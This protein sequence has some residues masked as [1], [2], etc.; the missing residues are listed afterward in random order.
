MF[1]FFK[2]HFIPHE[3]NDHQP[4]FLRDR[5]IRSLVIIVLFFEIGTFLIPYIP[6][7]DPANNAYTASVLPSVLDDLTNQNRQSQNL[8]VLSVNPVLN[9][10]AQLK[11]NDM[12]E[13]GYFAHIS[14][15]GKAPWYFF[16]KAGYNYEYAGENLAVDFTDSV[17][18]DT[19]WMNSPSHKANILKNAYTEIGTGIAT[20]T[21][22][23]SPT[24][25]VA[26][27]FGKPAKPDTKNIPVKIISEKNTVGKS[28]LSK[29]MGASIEV[30]PEISTS[31]IVAATSVSLQNYSKTNVLTQ[32]I[33]SPRHIVNVILLII[34]LIVIFALLLKLLIKSDK[35]HPVLITNGLIVI[36]LILGIYIVNN[37][38]ARNRFDKTSSFTSFVGQKFDQVK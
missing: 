29:V 5:N 37:Y 4:H 24:I 6:V 14:P 7:L 17:D 20:G 19:A 31:S 10:V 38:I 15:D 13:K 30:A 8:S 27:E 11:A 1:N 28:K 22:E 23:G 12:A 34:V 33:T 36:V 9:E 18:V 26:Q 3:E 2:K 32:Y 35:K 25:F 21:Y 16:D